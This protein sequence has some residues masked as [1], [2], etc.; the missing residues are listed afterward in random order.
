MKAT[1]TIYDAWLELQDGFV[2]TG[3][4]DGRPTSGFFPLVISQTSRAGLLFSICLGKTSEGNLKSI[5]K[6]YFHLG[7]ISSFYDSHSQLLTTLSIFLTS[8]LLII[9][10]EAVCE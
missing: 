8:G 5:I 4:G 2:H 7:Q 1:L 10:G 9:W 3:E 6:S